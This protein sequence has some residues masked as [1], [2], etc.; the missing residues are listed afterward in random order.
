MYRNRIFVLTNFQGIISN[1]ISVSVDDRV[2]SVR[3]KEAPGWIPYFSCDSPKQGVNNVDNHG[4]FQEQ[5]VVNDF[6]D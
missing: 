3:I 6:Y 5:G 1:V 2:F 4:H